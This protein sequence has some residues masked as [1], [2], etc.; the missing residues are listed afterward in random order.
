MRSVPTMRRPTEFLPSIHIAR[1]LV[2]GDSKTGTCRRTSRPGNNFTKLWEP[3]LRRK[4]TT[5][6]VSKL[7]EL[8]S[9]SRVLLR[10]E[11]RDC[12]SCVSGSVT[13]GSIRPRTRRPTMA[14]LAE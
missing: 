13:F 5:C 11:P 1:R 2:N 8:R 10:C 6:Q 4:T 9:L 7:D 12:V 14:S 3:S